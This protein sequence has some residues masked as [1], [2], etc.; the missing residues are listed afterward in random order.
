MLRLIFMGSPDFAVPALQA[1]ARS[2]H[3]ILAV[4]SNP[5]RKRGRGS[6]KTPTAVKE[7]ALE[8]KLPVIDVESTNDPAF[9]ERIRELK[10][11]LL[12]VVAFRILPEELLEIPLQGSIN[13]HAS[14]LPAYRGAAPIHWAVMN[15]ETK[16]G[17]TTFF[18]NNRVDTGSII[19]QKETP[20]GPDET[21]GELYDR[22]K[23]VGAEMVL[24]TVDRIDSGRVK[25]VPQDGSKASSAPKLFRENT[26]VDFRET[27]KRVHNKIRGLSPFPTAWTLYNGEKMNLYRSAMGP[28]YELKPGQLQLDGEQLLVGCSEGT[29]EIKELQLPG[30]NRM[31]GIDFANGYDL[32]TPLENP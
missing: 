27:S 12:V 9:I 3:E 18:L 13:L 28:R 10:P 2:D 19:L 26:R 16:S 8:L 30:R 29:V 5:D 4:A 17:C 25:V 6:V 15:G 14:L 24:E 22:L 1:L 23:R 7:T 21:A 20:V 32:N 31:S 11:D